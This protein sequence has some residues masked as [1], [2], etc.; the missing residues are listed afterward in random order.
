MKGWREKIRHNRFLKWSSIFTSWF[1]QGI[2]HS[3]LTEKYYRVLFTIF[4]T[5]ISFILLNDDKEITKNIF[6][7]F[8]IAHSLNWL[9]NGPIAAIFIHRLFIGKA[10]RKKVF[11]YLSNL[12]R[13]LIKQDVICF[14]AVFGSITRGELKDSSDIDVGFLRRP[15]IW[16][17]FKGLYFITKERIYANLNGIP[18]DSYLVDSIDNMMTRF[19]EENIPVL[20]KHDIKIN[21]SN[22]PLGNSLEKARILNQVVE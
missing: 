3:D 8:I 19:S 17:A 15:G 18:L 5:I 10:K 12:E 6:I 22:F 7:S 1:N 11:K 16:N 9:I 13:R 21:P 4:F 2:F 14:C 20:L